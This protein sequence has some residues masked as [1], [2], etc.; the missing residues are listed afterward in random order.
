MLQ[1]A[2]GHY[3]SFVRLIRLLTIFRKFPV[4]Y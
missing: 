2:A 1:Q 3:I 4:G